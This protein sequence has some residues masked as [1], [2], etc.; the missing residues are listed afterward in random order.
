VWA[1]VGLAGSWIDTLGKGH[2][3]ARVSGIWKKAGEA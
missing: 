1:C 3:L 2:V